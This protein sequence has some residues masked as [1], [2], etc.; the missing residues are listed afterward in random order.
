MLLLFPAAF[1]SAFTRTGFAS[2]LAAAT[3][4][5][6]AP[7]L[8][9]FVNGCPGASF[10]FFFAHAALLVAA[11]DLRRFP[12]LFPR[13]FLFA[14]SCHKTLLLIGSILER[15]SALRRIYR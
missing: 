7:A 2:F 5:F 12:F 8:V 3:A 13:I 1:S 15:R 4:A 14:S 6:F 9:G 10:R 11:L